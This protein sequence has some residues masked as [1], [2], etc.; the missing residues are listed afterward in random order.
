MLAMF[1]CH[2]ASD[3]IDWAVALRLKWHLRSVAA[4]CAAN[5][6]N[7]L[8]WI[9]TT[10]LSHFETTVLTAL[11]SI[12]QTSL[13]KILLFSSGEV[14]PLFAISTNN[15]LIFEHCESPNQH[16]SQ[17]V[18]AIIDC[19]FSEYQRELKMDPFQPKSW[20]LLDIWYGLPIKYTMLSTRLVF[21]FEEL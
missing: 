3:A 2:Q 9:V 19:L 16:S 1:D 21:G 5:F 15:L 8:G 20:G 4:T 12:R 18:V 17:L 11:G 14:E 7:S 6:G 13:S 10:F